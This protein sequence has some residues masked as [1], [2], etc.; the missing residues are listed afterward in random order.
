MANIV[1][2]LPNGLAFRLRDRGG[3]VSLEFSGPPEN[4]KKVKALKAIP[5]LLVATA[6][7]DEQTIDRL[8][9]S[10]EQPRAMSG[11]IV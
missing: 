8:R 9:N 2:E 1:Y 3:N 11:R 4:D 5:D 7:V 6:L 10:L